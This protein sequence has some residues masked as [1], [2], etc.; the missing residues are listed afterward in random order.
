MV[1]DFIWADKIPEAIGGEDE[2]LICRLDIND[3]DG[4]LRNDADLMGYQVSDSSGNFQ[5]GIHA[6]PQENSLQSVARF[7]D[8]TSLIVNPIL[9]ILQIGL[10]SRLSLKGVFG[11]RLSTISEHAIANPGDIELF[12]QLNN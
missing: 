11:L 3:F 10:V 2:K 9:F 12:L 4:R 6:S 8:F 1:N 5:A 7:L